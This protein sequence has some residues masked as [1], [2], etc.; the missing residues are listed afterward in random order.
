VIFRKIWWS[1][2]KSQRKWIWTSWP[3]GWN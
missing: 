3:W 1:L 2:C